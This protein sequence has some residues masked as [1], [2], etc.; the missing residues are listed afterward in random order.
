MQANRSRDTA[1]ELALRRL[2]HAR[3]LR[4]RVATRPLPGVR[5]TADIVFGPAKV[6]VFVDGCFWHRCPDHSAEPKTNTD[7]WKPKFERTVKRDREIDALLAQ[8]GWLSVRVWEHDDPGVAAVQV[9]RIV[10]RRRQAIGAGGVSI[11]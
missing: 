1:P 11:R 5:R 7:Y 3:G 9:A 6:A 10:R 2:L 4:Y 8:A